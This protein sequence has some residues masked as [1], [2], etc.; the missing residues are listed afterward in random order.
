MKSNES[1]FMRRNFLKTSVVGSIA[2]VWYAVNPV[3]L[4]RTKVVN[5]GNNKTQVKVHPLAIKRNK[6]G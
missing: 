1:S 5:S 2:G 6:K 3:K 4:L